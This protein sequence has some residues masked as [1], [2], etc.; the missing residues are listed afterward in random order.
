[1][2]KIF[3]LTAVAAA[4]ITSVNSMADDSGVTL[5]G[6]LN[7]DVERITNDLSNRRYSR[8]S[9]NSSF[10][11]FA[12][13]E[14]LGSELKAIWQVESGP[15]A[16][17]DAA[18][19]WSGRNSGVGLEGSFGTIM[20]GQWDT[21]YKE[22]LN[23]YDV[24]GGTSINDSETIFGN[25]SQTAGNNENTSFERRQRNMALYWS[26]NLA[27]F[28]GKLMVGT[29]EDSATGR[30]SMYSGSA[31]YTNGPFLANLAGEQHNNY[32]SFA[33]NDTGVRGGASFKVSTLTVGAAF[34][35]LRYK[36][37]AGDLKRDAF[38][39]SAKYGIGPGEIRT[40]FTKAK[41]GKGLVGAVA[42]AI[43]SKPESGADLFTAGYAYNFSKRTELYGFYTQLKNEKNGIYDFDINPTNGVTAGAT[44]K[45]YALGVKHLF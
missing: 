32:T 35:Q 16:D 40:Q 17:G 8:L 11:R 30:R 14:S 12:G 26:P 44:L 20:I 24:W 27:G 1:M 39:V 3:I 29:G 21:P 37:A 38:H 45:G 9:S 15:R 34:E 36:F 42:K 31:T 25:T 43:S 5:S 28:R 41:S 6:R 10:V 19:G 22:A 13:K 23:P 18:A 33:G 4:S 2:K 7:V